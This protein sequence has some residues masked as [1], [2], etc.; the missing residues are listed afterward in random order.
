MYFW[1][2]GVGN[3]VHVLSS[4]TNKVME[5]MGKLV[6]IRGRSDGN[7]CIFWPGEKMESKILV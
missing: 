7:I 3:G 6:G 2:S 4:I 5:T 1:V